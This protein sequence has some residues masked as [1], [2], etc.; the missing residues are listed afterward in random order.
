MS[1]R[2]S[3][4]DH[5]EV[6]PKKMTVIEATA[7]PDDLKKLYFSRAVV[8]HSRMTSVIDQFMDDCLGENSYN[9]V[10]CLGPSG[11]GKTRTLKLLVRGI[12]KTYAKAMNDDP[13]IIPVIGIEIPEAGT[14]QFAYST[15]FSDLLDQV[16]SPCPGKKVETVTEGGSRRIKP[17]NHGTSTIL[18][19]QMALRNELIVRKTRVVILDEASHLLGHLGGRDLT[20]LANALKSLG[21]IAGTTLVLVGAYDLIDV[22]ELSGQLA[23]R[24]GVIHFEPY[25][26][27]DSK[28]GQEDMAEFKNVLL[29]L[30]TMLPTKT[31]PDLL[32]LAEGLQRTCLGCVG[33]LKQVL[34]GALS[35]ALA[36]GGEWRLEHIQESILST[37]TLRN[38]RNE[39]TQGQE[40]LA[41]YLS[42]PSLLLDGATEL[43]ADNGKGPKRPRHQRAPRNNKGVGP[44]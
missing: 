37:A 10:V 42:R 1:S 15:L 16:S 3:E 9:I 21:N 27:G 40:D 7:I 28:K 5:P 26:M 30:Q 36:S 19:Q 29:T 8:G 11:I 22:L 44:V 25:R 31:Q 32:G 24:T 33:I 17:L 12:T 34:Q 2:F 13:G 6:N 20:N 14:R 39:I 38:L 41:E 35:K 43:K 4:H 23:R 18:A